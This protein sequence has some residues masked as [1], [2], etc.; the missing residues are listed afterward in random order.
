[1]FKFI[2]KAKHIDVQMNQCCKKK[3]LHNMIILMTALLIKNKNML[4]YRAWR[5]YFNYLIL[6]VYIISCYAQCLMQTTTAC[7]QQLNKTIIINTQSPMPT[8]SSMHYL[9]Y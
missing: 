9:S 6:Q 2:N 4:I 1:M 8:Q 7:G 3:I 5:T